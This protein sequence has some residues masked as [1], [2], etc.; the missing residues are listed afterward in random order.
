MISFKNLY[1]RKQKEG[2]WGTIFSLSYCSLHFFIFLKFKEF[3]D[4]E[5]HI[6][7][8]H[9]F[10]SMFFMFIVIL[11][12]KKPSWNARFFLILLCIS[13]HGT[14]SLSFL[15]VWS[16]TQGSYSLHMVDYI[17]NKDD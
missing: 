1:L 5:K 16:L 7:F 11:I 4:D 2:I 6:F 13:L 10:S 9:F 12:S 8:F 14:Y 17:R 15:E 3:L